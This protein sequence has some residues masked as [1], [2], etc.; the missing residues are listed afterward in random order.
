MAKNDKTNAQTAPQT[1]GNTAAQGTA[2]ATQ[3]AP[4]PQPPQAQTA[5]PQAPQ[6]PQAAQKKVYKF[7]SNNKFLTC[8]SLGVQFINGRAETESLEIAKALTHISG[9]TMVEE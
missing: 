8:A 1:T 4:P 9:V 2:P 3:T 7:V 6:P 5:P